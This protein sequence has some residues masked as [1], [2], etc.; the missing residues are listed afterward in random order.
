MKTTITT[1]N[2]T[3]CEDILARLSEA[4]L[5]DLA[6]WRRFE[7]LDSVY[8]GGKGRAA[9]QIEEARRAWALLSIDAQRT[10]LEMKRAVVQD[11]VDAM[12]E[13]GTPDTDRDI[14]AVVALLGHDHPAF[15]ILPAYSLADAY[16]EARSQVEDS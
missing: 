16:M 3:T 9:W 10:Y 11:L 12:R 15:R 2:R 6:T 7:D 5:S 4:D 13:V 14:D 8:L 1:H